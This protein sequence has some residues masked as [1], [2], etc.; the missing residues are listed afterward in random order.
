[1]NCC[2]LFANTDFSTV[3][4]SCLDLNKCVSYRG[5]GV[6]YQ[7]VCVQADEIEKILCHKFMRFMMMRAENFVVLR[8]KPVE[9]NV[10]LCLVAALHSFTMESWTN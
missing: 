1:M 3:I 5:S 2:F 10:I 6:S 9:V 4:R 8:R 7:C